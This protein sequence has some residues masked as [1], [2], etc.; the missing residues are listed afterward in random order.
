MITPHLEIHQ[1]TKPYPTVA[2]DLFRQ[3]LA[4]QQ[5]LAEQAGYT[6]N[7]RQQMGQSVQ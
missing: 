2:Y 1:C 6:I 4:H 3:K 5:D 7:L